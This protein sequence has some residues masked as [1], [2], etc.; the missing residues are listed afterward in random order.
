MKLGPSARGTLFIQL[1]NFPTHYLVI[2]ITDEAFQYALITTSV[3]SDSIYGSMVMEDIAWLDFGRIRGQE[4]GMM[5]FESEHG[6]HGRQS[7]T[8]LRLGCVI[9]R[10]LV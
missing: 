7:S 1:T 6:H 2:V 9:S 10:L 8:N 5:P 4:S 3:I